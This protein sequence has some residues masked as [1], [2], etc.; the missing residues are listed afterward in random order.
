MFGALQ[1]VRRARARETFVVVPMIAGWH[2][3]CAIEALHMAD[4]LGDDASETIADG[5]NARAIEFRR[6][7]VEQVVHAAVSELAFEDIERRQFAGLLDAEAALHEQLHERPVP[8]RRGFGGDR[9]SIARRISSPRCGR[10]MYAML[11]IIANKVQ[12]FLW[13]NRVGKSGG[14]GSSTQPPGGALAPGAGV[15]VLSRDGMN[16]PR[17]EIATTS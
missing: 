7:D 14:A 17:D 2:G 16:R 12:A 1:Q 6:L 8:K 15:P 10:I 13:M 9:A 5:N 11:A 3:V 4:D